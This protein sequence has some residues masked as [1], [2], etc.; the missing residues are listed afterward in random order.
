MM[1]PTVKEMQTTS[2]KEAD[3]KNKPR[4]NIARQRFDEIG[5][6]LTDM[7]FYFD[8]AGGDFNQL[9]FGRRDWQ[10]YQ[11]I[12]QLLRR[13]GFPASGEVTV[14]KKAVQLFDSF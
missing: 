1:L 3:M 13:A 2:Q 8:L 9:P 11:T 4:V 14:P 10:K 5:E 7:K 6:F 12:R